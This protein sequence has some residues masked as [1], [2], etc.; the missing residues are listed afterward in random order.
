MIFWKILKQIGKSKNLKQENHIKL[1]KL[2]Y[3]GNSASEGVTLDITDLIDELIKVKF[4][5]RKF[6]EEFIREEFH[7]DEIFYINNNGKFSE[8]NKQFK[9]VKMIVNVN[10]KYA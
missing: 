2:I 9:N 3:Y 7:A 4:L 8:I 5:P 6:V 1:W 10:E